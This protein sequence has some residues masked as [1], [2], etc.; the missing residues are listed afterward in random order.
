[1]SGPM[2]SNAWYRV[3]DLKP[4]LRTH[5]RLHRHVY[6][7]EVWYLLQDPVSNRTHRFTPS[8]RLFIAAMDGQRSVSELWRMSQRRLGDDAPTQDEVIQLLGQ[9]H[10]ADLLQSDVMPDTAE[11]HERGE[12]L[13][14]ATWISSRLNPMS[15]RI[16]LWDPNTLL[17]RWMPWLGRIWSRTGG[18][19]WLIVMGLALL[20][21][22]SHWSELSNNFADRVL[23][24]DNLFLLWLVF[25]II[26]LAHEMGHAVAT[27]RGGGE[28]HDMGV[29]LLVMIPVPYVE[30]SAASVFKSKYERA[31]VGAA[32][33]AVELFLAALAFLAWMVVEPGI[34]RALLFNVMIVAGVSTLIFN[35]NPLLRYDA[36]YMLADLIEM[37]NLAGR[38]L[39]YWGDLI[40]RRAFGARDLP[41]LDVNPS[42][43]GWLLFYGAASSIYRV[44]VT[45]SIALFIGGQFFFIGVLLAS[46]AVG[47]MALWPVI[48]GLRHI[49]D[50]P[51]LRLHR[52][53]AWGV[54]AAFVAM[55]G[56]LLFAVPAPFRSVAEGVVWL[57][58]QA[59]V[60]LGHEGFLT[61]YV[62]APGSHVHAGQTLLEAHDPK[63][64]AQIEQAQAR[65]AESQ[66]GYGAK[67][68][69]DRAAAM[70]ALEQLHTD[71][72]NLADLK[73]RAEGLVA[74][75]A[76]D[77]IF[78]VPR[79]QDLPGRYLK[80]G[81]LLG[82]VMPPDRTDAGPSNPH[83]TP[84]THA[85]PMPSRLA[86]VVVTQDAIDLVRHAT[87]KVLVRYAHQPDVVLE[88]RVIREVPSGAEYL[89]SRAL[90]TDG[91]GQL[92]TDPRDQKG[93]KTMERT[94]QF[95][96]AMDSVPAALASAHYGERV[97]V[98]F[99]H[100]REPLGMQMWRGV[101]RLFLSHFQV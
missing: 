62:A 99:D 78:T 50:S 5:A 2:L 79:A 81:D 93:A 29:V 80:R 65:V 94:F 8:A 20:L 40:E 31:M 37:P 46:W 72:A 97:Y 86:R 96:V 58:E 7:G 6:R 23:A 24:V 9:L 1:M 68:V 56:T 3:A 70:M 74:K 42:E 82:Y 43:R 100:A 49:A 10:G 44:I 28:V 27:K 36:Y 77:G 11:V 35:G 53:R 90:T 73:Q 14:R 38:S 85:M 69:A 47:S 16:H 30:A 22:P 33:M 87:S 55:L 64:A 32:G 75:A 54:T 51:G 76:S 71:E 34:V 21:L 67:L 83:G 26:K 63:L 92:A 25:P 12:R 45:I 66:A 17:D 60:R 18:I 4:R 88:G 15:M 95:D 19:V 89:P 61:R 41:E 91:G 101:R 13:A 84:D 98:R 52:R 59:Q 57:P 48:K 39:R